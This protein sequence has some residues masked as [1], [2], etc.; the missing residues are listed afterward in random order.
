MNILLLF[1]QSLAEKWEQ[2]RM[3]KKKKPSEPQAPSYDADSASISPALYWLLP[4]LLTP[5]KSWCFYSAV[6]NVPQ[7]HIIQL[8]KIFVSS[9]LSTKSLNQHLPSQIL[10]SSP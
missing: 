5:T 6:T 3:L 7:N 8:A 2:Y 1:P 4:F 9:E 10:L